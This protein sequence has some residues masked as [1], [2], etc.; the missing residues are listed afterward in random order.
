MLSRLT[1]VLSS[2]VVQ[3]LEEHVFRAIEEALDKAEL[4]LQE[5]LGRRTST[6]SFVELRG[7][8]QRNVTGVDVNALLGLPPNASSE[9]VKAAYRRLA[10]ACGCWSWWFR[11][12]W[13]ATFVSMGKDTHRGIASER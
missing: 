12:I 11:S 7:S 10:G 8:A 1:T 5:K 3:V 4:E 6:D 13:Q 9:E 2:Q